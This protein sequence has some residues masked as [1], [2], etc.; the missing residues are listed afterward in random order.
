MFAMLQKSISAKL[1]PTVVG[2]ACMDVV[3]NPPVSGDPS[4]A[5]F[6]AQVEN[7]LASYAERAKLVA[8]T[9]N[10]IPVSPS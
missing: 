5:S 3:V 4:F 10:T 6:T 1:C 2:Q 8:D 7:T 9:L